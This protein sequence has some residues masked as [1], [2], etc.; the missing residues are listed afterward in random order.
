[1]KSE[2]DL[3]MKGLAHAFTIF[4]IVQVSITAEVAPID[5]HLDLVN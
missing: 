1:M 4:T 5:S 3:K 2:T